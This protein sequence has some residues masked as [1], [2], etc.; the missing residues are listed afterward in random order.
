[1]IKGLNP[2]DIAAVDMAI[3]LAVLV[4]IGFEID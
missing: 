1:M 2:R 3:T 4:F